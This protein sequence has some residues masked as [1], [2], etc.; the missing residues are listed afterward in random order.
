V[1]KYCV[2]GQVSDVNMARTHCM[3]DPK[4]YVIHNLASLNDGD[5]F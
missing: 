3:L 5:T 2:A 1:E 4:T